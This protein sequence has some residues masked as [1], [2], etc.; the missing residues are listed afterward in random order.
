M[1]IVANKT[2]SSIGELGFKF[3]QLVVVAA[4]AEDEDHQ[5]HRERRA[6]HARLRPRLVFY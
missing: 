5:P 1:L 6:N 4:R 3:L 2:D